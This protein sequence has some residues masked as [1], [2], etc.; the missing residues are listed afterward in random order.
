M[1]TSL[2]DYLTRYER[3]PNG[4]A[5]D[6]YLSTPYT[7]SYPPQ[8][9]KRPFQPTGD[10]AK[11]NLQVLG[12]VYYTYYLYARVMSS[13]R[14]AYVIRYGDLDGDARYNYSYEL[15]NALPQT[16]SGTQVWV[17]SYANYDE[18]TVGLKYF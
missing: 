10:W 7:P 8:Q 17:E 12:G 13:Q 6:N 2:D 14:Y 1:K 18:W 3:Y 9:Y 16:V 5:A 11:L 15:W 4:T